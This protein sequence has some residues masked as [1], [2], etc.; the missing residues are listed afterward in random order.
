MHWHC[1]VCDRAILDG[2]AM[3][4][5]TDVA[6]AIEP[7]SARAS[8]APPIELGLAGLAAEAGGGGGGG[9]A[10]KRALSKDKLFTGPNLPACAALCEA[11]YAAD[12]NALHESNPETRGSLERVTIV[13]AAAPRAQQLTNVDESGRGRLPNGG[14]AALILGDTSDPDPLSVPNRFVDTRSLFFDECS[15][16]NY[17]FDTLRRSKHSTMMV[18]HRLHGLHGDREG[19]GGAAVKAE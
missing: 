4:H 5:H 3:V 10:L 9:G 7:G 6:P 2:P 8:A 12:P 17:N 15:E 16:G 1:T 19:A 18:L 14:G 11:C 13:P